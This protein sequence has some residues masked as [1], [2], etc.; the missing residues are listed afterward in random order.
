MSRRFNDAKWMRKEEDELRA[1][2][3]S[4]EAVTAISMRL[5]RSE[6]AI[7]LRAYTLGLKLPSKKRFGF[8][9]RTDELGLKAKPK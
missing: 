6:K 2:A 8:P 3:A 9:R 5:C 7:Q 4:G 1:L